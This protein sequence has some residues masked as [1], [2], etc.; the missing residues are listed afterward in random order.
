[1]LL[2]IETEGLVRI[3]L[4]RMRQSPHRAVL[5][6]VLDDLLSGVEDGGMRQGFASLLTRTN[7]VMI[8][9]LPSSGDA[10]GEIMILA[11]GS[12]DPDEIARLDA[13]GSS[14]DAGAVIERDGHRVWVGR[15]PDDRT[16]IVQLR[17]DTLALTGSMDQMELLLAR[18][19][20]RG[21]SPR[22][23]P[24]LRALV[25]ATNLEQATFGLALANR[26]LGDEDEEEPLTMSLAGC[27]DVDG[28]LD[29]EVLVEVGEPALAQMAAALVAS[30]LEEMARSAN[31]EA[32]A[33]RRLAQLA[34]I[35]T[36]GSR[37][38]GSIHADRAA[39]DE[40][41]PSLMGMLRQELSGDPDAPPFDPSM[42]RTL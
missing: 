35:E 10:E 8:A 4:S 11:N 1:M 19:R 39:A 26:S 22:W 20:M 5:Q 41:V 2:P 9:L 15:D 12:Y 6:P 34:R 3:D 16:A 28:P 29:I 23:P 7:V 37:I 36:S 13:S 31:A 32:F 14:A 33:L 40:L 24:S 25:E 21:S 17:P 42:P 30:M 18:T 38:L 27:A